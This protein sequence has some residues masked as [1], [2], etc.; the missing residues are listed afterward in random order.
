M[1]L[2][3]LLREPRALQHVL[4][5]LALSAVPGSA[6]AQ[7]ESPFKSRDSNGVDIVTGDIT[8]TIG[9]VSI[10]DD[11]PKGLE[12]RLEQSSMAG[13]HSNLDVSIIST[14]DEIFGVQYISVSLDGETDTFLQ[15]GALWTSSKH[16]GAS[17][18]VN[19]GGYTY[20]S[21]DG[22]G[23]AF[24]QGA[25]PHGENGWTALVS[26][27]SYPEGEEISYNYKIQKTCPTG[28]T[29]STS[30]P[31]L[32]GYK[33]YARVQ[34]ITS[35]LGYQIKLSY[36]LANLPATGGV[37]AATNWKQLAKVQAINTKVEACDPVADTC[38]L[39]YPWP[40]L[41]IVHTDTGFTGTQTVVNTVTDSLSRVTRAT[42]HYASTSSQTVSI[43][44]PDSA[45]D[46]IVAQA[47]PAYKVTSYTENGRTWS[48]NYDVVPPADA[49]SATSVTSPSGET[50]VYNRLYG[51]PSTV[52]ADAWDRPSQIQYSNGALARIAYDSWGRVTGQ[53]SPEGDSGVYE[54]DARGNR[55]RTTRHAKSG[56]G[57]AD[58]VTTAT[59]PAS[60]TNNVICNLPT[61]TVDPAG[62]VTDYTYDPVTGQLLTETLPAPSTGAARPQTRNSYS[63]LAT[64]TV[65]VSRLSKVSKCNSA[66]SCVG[67]SDEF[68]Q[69]TSYGTP[70]LQATVI[71]THSGDSAVSSS[72]SVAYDAL[73]N[74]ASL[75]GP[76]TGSG[77][78]TVTRY[79][80]MG[81]IVG[82][83]EPDPDG[84]GPLPNRATRIALD[85][86]G[87]PIFEERGT[88]N[89][90]TDL[91]WSG[92]SPID[93]VATTYDGSGRKTTAALK[94]GSTT[95]ALT[96]YGYDTEGRLQCTAVRMNPAVYSSL[97]G[98]CTL[99]TQGSAG[100]D[101][102]AKISYDGLDR[103][104]KT[105]SALGTADQSDDVSSTYTLNGKPLTVADANGNL[106]TFVYDGYDRLSQT[107]YPSP[108]TTGISSTTDY[109]GLSYDV[110]G[111]VLQRRE[112][113][114]GLVQF[115]YDKL[116]RTILIDLPGVDV[117]DSDI[118]NEYDL[119]N[120]L[121]HTY[122]VN[123]HSVTRGYDALG[124]T[125][126]Q[127]SNWAT[128]GYQYDSAGRRTR[129]TWPDGL[130]VTYEYRT[131]GEVSAVRE[132]GATS[133][134]G[135]LA[136]YAY[137]SS[138][139]RVTL[140]RGNGVITTG[141]FDAISRL[142]SFTQDL[143]GT[144]QDLTS[145]FTYNPASQTMSTTR[146]ND[147]YAWSGHYNVDRPYGV[148][149]LNQ[150]TTAGSVPLSYDGRGNLT[151]SGGSVYHYNTKNQLSN[152]P[153][154]QTL[155]YDPV[156]RL[157]KL[158]AAGGSTWSSFDHDGDNII[159]EYANDT[160]TILRRYVYGPGTDNPLVWYEGAG[161]SDRRWL[162]PN[163]QGSVIA[164]T[165]TSG[166]AIAINS[167]DEYGIPASSNLGLFQYTGQAWL[168]DIGL[169]YYKARIY[170]P[171]LGRFMQTDPIGYSDGPNWYNYVSGDPVNRSDPSGLAEVPNVVPDIIVTGTCG[172]GCITSSDDRAISNALSTLA[173][174][175]QRDQT[176]GFAQTLD[177]F[178]GRPNPPAA[179]KRPGAKPSPKLLKAIIAG[180]K[181]I[182]PGNPQANNITFLNKNFAKLV[183]PGK[184]DFKGF[185]AS[186]SLHGTAYQARIPGY[187]D[188]SI[189]VYV[190]DSDNGG[191]T[192][193]TIT[194]TFAPMT[195]FESSFAHVENVVP[196][197]MGYP[198]NEFTA[199]Q[200]CAVAGC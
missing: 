153:G 40:K 165:G 151:V 46:N 7:T 9:R 59:F 67:T 185:K 174:T 21:A 173:G 192:T 110:N 4:A 88:T 61:S 25:D 52:F 134:A 80:A 158:I 86:A 150:L 172:I 33:A 83:I 187:T 107:R 91:A 81:Q 108:T 101:R 95:Y 55:F 194:T 106:T 122:D 53:T 1:K 57:L 179:K 11:Y 12:Y 48:Y 140:T 144:A 146:S 44:T 50:V 49:T 139:R 45:V 37:G 175:S 90:Q 96:Q 13:L 30:A 160:S 132:N 189:K 136:T 155:Y 135:V 60:C 16:A 115:G 68:V 129:M 77:D 71:T 47:T 104:I 164:V 23:V 26:K 117:T 177:P 43:K 176:N 36:A 66:S 79:D 142:S 14:V 116:N 31:G 6:V 157:D 62:N 28:I 133:G 22:V 84:A 72:M 87:R 39:S 5:C 191:L 170:S 138:G 32:S 92:F 197:E 27:V 99:G 152:T 113:D 118:H 24:T 97:P 190:A 147:S 41:D 20:T 168:S 85:A 159:T 125:I 154:G 69:E 74:I 3:R 188:F 126:S 15:D 184:F 42:W 193:I 56:S 64:S 162:I 181:R 76:L 35:N 75:D 119:L 167:Y 128:T 123:G 178:T 38:A 8:K 199:G 112:R 73:G 121:T 18:I 54:L 94:N 141:A 182:N 200:Y 127:A 70:N 29:C 166:T 103:P 148:N 17:L 143:A 171:N 19:T 58:L 120:R 114:G 161:T 89:G 105:Q 63:L 82:T 111:N 65:P 156:G 98:A 93:A 130:Y 145:T 163:E 10:G 102:I 109:E 196:Y 137:D 34:S 131:T 169:Y 186:T 124:R 149:G 180:L 2:I 78:T 183:N 100:P 198:V 51:F 195:N